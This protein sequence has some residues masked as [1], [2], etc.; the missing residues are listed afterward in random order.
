MLTRYHQ[1]LA[2]GAE[3][4]YKLP[5]PDWHLISVIRNHLLSFEASGFHYRF[6]FQLHF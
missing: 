3:T 5:V 4:E 1:S 2:T 6:S